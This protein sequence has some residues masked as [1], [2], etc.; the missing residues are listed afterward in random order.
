MK[1][2]HFNFSECIKVQSKRNITKSSISSQSRKFISHSLINRQHQKLRD[3]LPV[4]GSNIPLF[5]DKILYNSNDYSNKWNHNQKRIVSNVRRYAKSARSPRTLLVDGT[6][7][8]CR[9][10]HGTKQEMSTVDGIP[11]NGVLTYI[12]TLIRSMPASYYDYVAVF[13]E[14]KGNFRK[15]LFDEYKGTREKQDDKLIMQFPIAIEATHLMKVHCESMDQYEADDL[16]ASYTKKCY[17]AGHEVHILTNDKDLFQMVNEKVKVISIRDGLYDRRRIVHKFG[18]PPEKFTFLQSLMGDK[19]DNIPGVPGIGK[20]IAAEIANSFN[21]I[22]H[23]L[24]NINQVKSDK[25]RMSILENSDQLKLSEKL[26]SLKTDLIT[27]DFENFRTP[28]TVNNPEFIEFLKK[29]EFNSILYTLSQEKGSSIQ[30]RQEA[31]RAIEPREKKLINI[32]KS[33][34]TSNTINEELNEISKESID[35]PK[36]E[37]IEINKNL[38]KKSKIDE[39]IN[40]KNLDTE[41][42]KIE[43]EINTNPTLDVTSEYLPGYQSLRTVSQVRSYLNYASQ[44]PVAISSLLSNDGLLNETVVGISLSCEEGKSVYIPFV[45]SE[46]P[47]DYFDS[48]NIVKQ[49]FT[50]KLIKE[51]LENPDVKKIAV[52]MKREMKNFHQYGVKINNYEDAMVMSYVLYC[53]KHLHELPDLMVS[54]LGIADAKS[55]VL[56][57]KKIVLGQGNKKVTFNLAPIIPVTNF[58]CQLSDYALKSFKVLD[59]ELKKS[60]KLLSFYLKLEK[61]LILALAD[62]ELQGAVVNIEMFQKLQEEYDKK[63]EIAKSKILEE[64]GMPDLNINSPQQLGEALFDKMKIGLEFAKKSTKMD[65]YIVNVDVLN[66]MAKQGH[67]IAQYILEYRALIKI[68]STYILGLQKHINPITQRIHPTYMNCLTVTGRLSCTEPNLQNIPNRTEEGRQIRKLFIAPPGHC[69]MKVDYSQVELR[70]LAH[71]AKIEVLRDAFRNGADIHSTTAASIFGRPIDQ[72]KKEERQKAKSI[73]FGIIYGM[74]EFGLS[75]QINVSVEE[76]KDYISQY[77]VRYPGIQKYMQRAADFSK[78]FGFVQTFFGR[79]CWVPGISSSNHSVRSFA[80]RTSIN[81]PIQGSS[82]DITKIAMVKLH[83]LFAKKGLKTKMILQVHDEIVFEVPM[84]EME[85]VSKLIKETMESSDKFLGKPFSIPLPVDIDICKNWIE[86]MTPED[87]EEALK[88][89]LQQQ[90]EETENLVKD[91][92]RK[93]DELEKRREQIQMRRYGYTT[94]Q[95]TSQTTSSKTETISSITTEERKSVPLSFYTS[96]FEELND[97]LEESEHLE[98]HLDAT[99]S[100]FVTTATKNKKLLHEEE[101]DEDLDFDIV[102]IVQGRVTIPSDGEES[103]HDEMENG[104]LNPSKNP[105]KRYESDGEDELELEEASSRIVATEQ[106]YMSDEDDDILGDLTLDEVKP[107]KSAIK[108]ISEDEEDEYIQRVKM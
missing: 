3:F 43:E 48:V 53:G 107:F 13:F 86:K 80:E 64:C 56:I 45:E 58:A 41:T 44:F 47:E 50:F 83:E 98:D 31:R 103:D 40:Q 36:E 65:Q 2:P 79:K 26:V 30:S 100:T 24:E 46:L 4:I 7:L 78:K 89:S 33:T 67:K 60:K 101:E 20:K 6:P 97:D 8:V 63:I 57:D 108:Y 69:L 27:K 1:S 70:I 94:S 19:I 81:T 102:A 91:E 72:V 18:V 52:D 82:A 12:R 9:S 93:K 39:N 17:D 104:L 34:I 105:P 95:T 5:N 92:Q 106:P 71:I 66:S 76:A 68:Q 29:Y 85:E 22:E 38:K 49:S 21:G 59:S 88:V 10:F 87:K 96:S 25:V 74:S 42:I 75:K 15:A 90:K 37:K 28:K 51:F 55:K 61:P 62:I 54:V 35:K 11:T 16:I 99:P 84:Y 32:D 73:N 14:S 23:L 77:F